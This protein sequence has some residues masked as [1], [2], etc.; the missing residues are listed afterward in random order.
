MA[1]VINGTGTVTGIS[2]GGLPDAIVDLDTLAANSVN[3]AKIVDG[4]VVAADIA[5]DA[6]TAAK[7]ANSI[8]TDIA[9]GVTANTTANAAL[10]TT[11]AA[12]TYA[13][14]A[15]PAFTGTPTGVVRGSQLNKIYDDGL[16][17]WKAETV[18]PVKAKWPKDNSGP[19]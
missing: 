10:P 8:N 17:K 12:S 1:I 18:D 15:S 9:T 19:V 4:T 3:A 7:L 2:V 13:P 11:T 16:T 14:K 6:V 5:D